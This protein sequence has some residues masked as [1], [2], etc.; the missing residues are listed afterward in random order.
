MYIYNDVVVVVYESSVAV[1]GAIIVP[2]SHFDVN[3]L[4]LCVPTRAIQPVIPR[5]SLPSSVKVYISI[6]LYMYTYILCPHICK[7]MKACIC[8][9]RTGYARETREG[10]DS[11]RRISERK[12]AIYSHRIHEPP[13]ILSKPVRTRTLCYEIPVHKLI[14]RLIGARAKCF[15]F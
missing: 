4:T 2:A 5:S 13:L 7:H 8:I 1:L 6:Y 11:Q 3:A 10:Y 15:L 14:S 9:L 12:R